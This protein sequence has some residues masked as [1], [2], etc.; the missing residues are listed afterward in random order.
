M[1]L[2]RTI[3]QL[4]EWGFGPKIAMRI[5]QKFREE[6][7]EYLTENPYRLIEEIEGVGFQR[8]D[9]LGRNLGIT[10]DNPSRIKAAV[11]HSM[12]EAVQSEG[13]VYIEGKVVLPDVKR[14]LGNESTH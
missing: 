9:E 14:L 5:Y 6:S 10:G 12:N 7:I 4:N 8:A 1:G 2:E 11:L 3:I 13:H